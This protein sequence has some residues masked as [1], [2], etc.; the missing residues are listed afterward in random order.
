MAGKISECYRL[1]QRKVGRGLGSQRPGDLDSGRN[2]QGQGYKTEFK[3]KEGV[4][5]T[6]GKEAVLFQVSSLG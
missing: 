1:G 2:S 3:T 4:R 6:K 5:R